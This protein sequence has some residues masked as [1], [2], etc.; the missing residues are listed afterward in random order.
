[1]CL[2]YLAG[3]QIPIISS[4]LTFKRLSVQLS[5]SV[6]SNS[7]WPHGLQHTRPPCPSPAPRVCSNSCSSSQWCYPIISS[8]VIP[9]SSCLQSFPASGSF[10]MGQFFASGGQSIR[11]SASASVKSSKQ[12]YLSYLGAWNGRK[13]EKGAR[14]WR[15]EEGSGNLT[16]SLDLLHLS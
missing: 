7:L 1:M 2:G 10:Q 15:R 13:R 6:V 4:A 11:V 5:C 14:M 12:Q 8:S 9:F 3:H 16:S